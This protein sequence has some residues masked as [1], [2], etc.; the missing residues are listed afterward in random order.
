MKTLIIFYK[1]N[2]NQSFLS[3]LST[4]LVAYGFQSA[5]FP[6]YNS[7]KV[8]SYYNGMLFTFLGVT[9][10]FLIYMMV[11]FVSIYS[12]GT[13][14]E[15]DVL[16]NVEEVD[17]W[18]SFILR[19]VFLL[20][21]STHTP[22]IFFIGKESLLAI[23]GLLYRKYAK[24]IKRRKRAKRRAL[25]KAKAKNI[26]KKLPNNG[27]QASNDIRDSLV[28]NES[29]SNY[30]IISNLNVNGSFE[31]TLSVESDGSDSEGSEISSD[32]GEQS[33]D[34][35]IIMNSVEKNMSSAIGINSNEDNEEVEEDSDDHNVEF[36]K[37]KAVG[38]EDILPIWVYYTTTL[39]LYSFV[40]LS[41]WFITDV[42]SVIKFIGSMANSTLNYT[43]PGVYYYI[44]LKRNKALD[45]PKWKLWIGLFFA[46]Y[47]TTMGIA[48]TAFN[49]WTTISPLPKHH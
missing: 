46:I 4:A 2:F 23:I 11:L 3:S 5:F 32:S 25:R 10:C 33:E 24:L 18:E 45:T 9:F 31:R 6:I 34:E 19:V 15:G 43:L 13:K 41:S 35:I 48:C 44:I 21:M 40:V 20:V 16:L 1:F 12:F 17:E 37:P 29:D 39:F 27:I 8:K 26:K 36:K 47:G 38:A 22:F 14:I 30:K 7:L 42:E 28:S 49:I